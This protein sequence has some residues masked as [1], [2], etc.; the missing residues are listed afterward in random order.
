MC[1]LVRLHAFIVHLKKLLLT[2]L[3]IKSDSQE[4]LF[5]Y[6]LCNHMLG[7]LELCLIHISNLL[8]K[9]VQLIVQLV[10]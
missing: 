7:H 2:P 3:V 9:V 6:G 1:C 8:E 4:R 5:L 10:D